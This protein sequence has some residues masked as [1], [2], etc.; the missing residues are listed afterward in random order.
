MLSEMFPI[1]L[2]CTVLSV[3]YST[4][5][6]LSAGLAPLM[7]LILVKRTGLA[8]SPSFIVFAEIAILIAVLSYRH[9]NTKSTNIYS[10][11]EPY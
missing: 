6:S 2:R 11:F 7:S 9:L 3:L 5:A 10:S 4:A 8:S 1:K